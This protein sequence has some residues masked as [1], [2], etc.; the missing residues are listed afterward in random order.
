MSPCATTRTQ[1]GSPSKT[2]AWASIRRRS[3][4]ARKR[5]EHLGLL[6]MTE[7]VRSAGGSIAL[8]SRPGRGSRIEV[9][10]PLDVAWRSSH[11]R[12]NY[13]EAS[14]LLADDHALVRAGIRA[15][16]ESLPGV[17]VVRESGRRARRPRARPPR[18]ARRHPARHHAAR[19]QWSRSGGTHHPA[20]VAD[21]RA[22]A[23]DA[24]L[25][26]ARRARAGRRR[27]RL[28]QQGLGLR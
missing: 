13:N 23:F 4:S 27:R 10:I 21:A 8:D 3:P 11:S 26:R 15:L 9:R 12:P 22:D 17:E 5:G 18:S 7:R 19:A 1:C 16:L 25:P 28:S 14:I 24:H 20:R 6:G 2:M